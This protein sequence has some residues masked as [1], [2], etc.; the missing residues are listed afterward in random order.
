MTHEGQVFFLKF[1]QMKK[2]ELC[3]DFRN[4]IYKNNNT[5]VN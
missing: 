3:H 4:L 5:D 1:K 2:I